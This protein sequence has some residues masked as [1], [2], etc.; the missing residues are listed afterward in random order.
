[1]QYVL[2]VLA[3][4]SVAAD[5]PPKIED[6]E[7]AKL[8]ADIKQ[9]PSTKEKLEAIRKIQE[10]GPKAKEA[11]YTLCNTLATHRNE[12]LRLAAAE[13]LERVNPE[14]AK[15]VVP[16]CTDGAE[17]VR[18]DYIQRIEQMGPQ[19]HDAKPVLLARLL[20]SNDGYGEYVAC[21]VALSATCP[22]DKDVYDLLLRTTQ[23][24]REYVRATAVIRLPKME[25]EDHAKGVKAV[26]TVLRADTSAE[27]RVAAAK[28]LGEYGREARSAIDQLRL[29]RGDKV[30]EVRETADAAIKQIEAQLANEK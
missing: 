30:A 1:M 12:Q 20:K 7:L 19:A 14:L 21:V 6:K 2:F 29:A 9:K 16:A 28:S 25:V 17:K 23:H 13:A 24:R 4:L 11:S 10:I 27:N 22:A 5:D 15:L 3:V 26:A 8:V 18:I